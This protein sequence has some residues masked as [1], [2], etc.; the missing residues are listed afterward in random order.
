M[1]ENRNVLS[2]RRRGVGI[3]LDG[4]M[5]P[6]H[7][8]ADAFR[9]RKDGDPENQIKKMDRLSRPKW[10]VNPLFLDLEAQN[11][12]RMNINRYEWRASL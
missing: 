2:K 3:L 10:P 6:F 4:S 7:E 11:S 8:A 9:G 12:E 5:M 1:S